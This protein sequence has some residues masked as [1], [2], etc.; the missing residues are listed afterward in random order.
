MDYLQ[1]V[2]TQR[3]LLKENTG[4]CPVPPLWRLV[5]RRV[6]AIAALNE[7]GN[8][9][10]FYCIHSL[11]GEVTEFRHLAR[12][13]GP[14]Q[15]F[16]GIQ[17]PREKLSA[18]FA[19]SVES[20]AEYYADCLCAFQPA[21]PFLLGGWSAG[22][23]IA[24][25]VAQQLNLR[26]R[27]VLLLVVIDGT[28]FNTGGGISAWNPLYWWKLA[29]NLPHWFA[30]DLLESLS[31]RVFVR[32]IVNKLNA[33]RKLATSGLQGESTRHGHAVA[34]F[35]DTARFSDGHRS[36]MSALFNA[37]HEYFP[38]KYAG[39]VLVYAAKTQPL[40]HLFQIEAVWAKI[41]A[42]IE[43]VPVS[44]THVSILREPHV[45]AVAD[46]LRERLSELSRKVGQS[47]QASTQNTV[48]HE[49]VA[50]TATV[51]RA[52]GELPSS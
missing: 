13:L 16:Y 12:F 49:R 46:D 26:G 6:G 17:T 2:V 20:M 11:G 31:F 39:Q 25:E 40:Y 24:L 19:A 8:G 27:E 47:A 33:F 45:I 28:P 10:A 5:S 48:S 52:A 34:G 37:L 4:L 7:S 43:I 51:A 14:E 36:F 15:R 3:A 23:T 1:E 9:L 22:S 32:R 29:C 42:R 44:G 38:K 50:F 30:D 18:E 21:G 35:M 41:A